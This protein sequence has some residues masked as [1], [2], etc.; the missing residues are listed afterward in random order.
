MIL[1]FSFFGTSA[2]QVQHPPVSGESLIQDLDAATSGSFKTTFTPLM[3]LVTA[4][5]TVSTAVDPC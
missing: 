4:L 5:R 1:C 3:G 2:D